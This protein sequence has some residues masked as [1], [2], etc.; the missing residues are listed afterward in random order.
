MKR[1]ESVNANGK[2]NGMKVSTE[3]QGHAQPRH[4]FCYMPPVHPFQT[5]TREYYLQLLLLM[6]IL[7]K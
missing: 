2:P 6:S 1:L 7:F 5:R 4:S 3:L